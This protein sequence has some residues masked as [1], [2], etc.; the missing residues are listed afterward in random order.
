MILFIANEVYISQFW[1]HIGAVQLIELNDHVHLVSKAG[2]V[3]L[4]ALNLHHL[5]SDEAAVNTQSRS[6]LTS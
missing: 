1:V 5:L 6:S 4:L 3:T 2:S